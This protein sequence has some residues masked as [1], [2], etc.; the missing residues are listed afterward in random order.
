MQKVVQQVLRWYAGQARALPWR[1]PGTTPWGVFVSEVMAQQTQVARV[2]EAW[3]R[4]LERWPTPAALAADSPAEAVRAWGGLGYPRRGLW[5]H[6][7]ARV[8]VDQ[9]GGQVPQS[10]AELRALPGV[11]QYTAAAVRAFAY[12][13]RVPVLDVNVRRVHARHFMGSAMPTPSITKAELEHHER[14]LPQDP[15]VAARL[16]QAVME[17]GS[18]VCS[19]RQPAC[20]TCPLRSS[21][22]WLAAGSPAPEAPPRRAARYEGSDRQ[23][24]GALLRALREA[25]GPVTAS[26]L[27]AVWAEALQRQRCLESLIADGLVERQPRQ[28]FALPQ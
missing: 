20:T 18:L 12:G 6:A 2:V 22:A 1:A 26:A 5:L 3:P 7:A 13:Q 8:M 27:E 10:D 15:Q 21:C 25:G 9:H 17:F 23:C 19:V 4:W 24:R 14:F 11:G 28:R 16:S